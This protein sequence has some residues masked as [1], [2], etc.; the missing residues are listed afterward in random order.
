MSEE[1]TALIPSSFGVPHA[2]LPEEVAPV[3]A[4]SPVEAPA[5]EPA[6][7]ASSSATSAMAVESYRPPIPSETLLPME[8]WVE[9]HEELLQS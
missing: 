1:A 9:T 5:V 6:T 4:V 2:I 3:G 8:A 7:G